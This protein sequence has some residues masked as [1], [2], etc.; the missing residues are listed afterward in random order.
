M[1]A[2]QEVVKVLPDE[3]V[4]QLLED[5]GT[6]DVVTLLAT[7]LG[8]D[9]EIVK[10]RCLQN[11][12]LDAAKEHRCLHKEGQRNVYLECMR[13]LLGQFNMKRYL[14]VTTAESQH[15]FDDI[16][17]LQAIFEQL[18]QISTLLWWFGIE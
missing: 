10:T 15:A 3:A 9:I 7:F 17:N 14:V 8:S 16:L 13:C 5:L 18:L 1:A 4:L 11:G 2:N 12:L 6:E